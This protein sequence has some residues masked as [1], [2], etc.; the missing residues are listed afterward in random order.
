MGEM[1]PQEVFEVMRRHVSPVVAMGA[2]MLGGGAL[3]VEAEGAAVRLSD[4]REVIDFGSYGLSLLGHRNPTV[5]AAVRE[6]MERMTVTT[7]MLASEVVARFVSELVETVGGPLEGVWLGS[8]GAD[9]VEAATKLARKVCGRPRVLAVRGGF[10]GKT[11]G[12]LAMT[13]EPDARAD[14][15]ALLGNVTHVDPADPAAV[16]DEVAAGDVAAL[17]LEPIQGES[18]VRALDLDVARRWAA[19]AK[20]AG[21]FVI[22]DEIQVGLR[23]CGPI[24][25][26]LDAGLPIDALLLG[27]ALGG[28]VMPLSAVLVTP[29]LHAP[30]AA[31]PTWHTSTF[32]LQPL[33]CAAGSGALRALEELAPRGEELGR[34]LDEALANLAD[35]HGALVTE[36]RGAGLLRGVAFESAEV[37]GLTMLGLA[38]RGVTVSPC[39]SS[40]DT[41]RLM[42]PMATT[43]EQL[44]R[45]F[46]IFSE[47]LAANA[48]AG[49]AA[50]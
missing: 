10:H 33:S 44:E 37:G 27:K 17:I 18:G 4:G 6:Q 3:E 47:T 49:A 50:G 20:A 29:E 7:R 11:L 22:S 16:A 38:Q 41:I 5:L 31:S 23:R 12:A 46:A 15:E 30:M 40:P 45:A 26:A 8:D 1:E 13:W 14:L 25:M 28:G 2:E 43:D 34:L 21:A 42:V 39:L 24:S 35:E 36:T 32:Q 9:A 19:D 48:A